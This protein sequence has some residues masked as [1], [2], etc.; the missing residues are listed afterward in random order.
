LL[1]FTFLV[2]PQKAFNAEYFSIR[3]HQQSLTTFLRDCFS[4]LRDTVSLE[5]LLGGGMILIIAYLYFSANPNASSAG[6][7][8][9]DLLKAFF[10]AL[11]IGFEFLLLWALFFKEQKRNLWWYVTGGILIIAPLILFGSSIDFSMRASIPALFLLMAWSGE[12]LFRRPKVKYYGALILLLI[13][14]AFTP[15]YEM[16]R[17]IYRTAHYYFG[18]QNL[19]ETRFYSEGVEQPN[20]IPELD[21]LLTL[22]ADL[23]PS[24]TVFNPEDIP[25]FVAKTNDSLFFKYLAPPPKY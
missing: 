17:T 25:N 13:I 15:L 20:P 22:T 7:I 6:F 24:L 16:N 9:M 3:W 5:N 2:I 18:E 8:E 14:G 19:V 4:D 1:P 21:H 12:A 11:F 23:Y 10:Y